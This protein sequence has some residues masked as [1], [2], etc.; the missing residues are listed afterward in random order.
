MER[1]LESAMIRPRSRVLG[2]YAR[3]AGLFTHEESVAKMTG[4][5]AAKLSCAGG[6]VRQD[7]FAALAL[8]DPATVCDEALRGPA[9]LS[10]R[11]PLRDRERQR[12][13]RRRALQRPLRQRVLGRA[14][15]MQ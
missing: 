3:D 14:S 8:F 4:Q 13:G 5:P 12:G 15:T 11:P 2:K 9:P 6:F 7:Y 1:A 10:E